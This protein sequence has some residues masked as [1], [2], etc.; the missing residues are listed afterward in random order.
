MKRVLRETKVK[1]RF[2]EHDLRAKASSDADSDEFAQKLL[3][4][5]NI[6]I[7]KRVY[8]RKAEKIV[9]LR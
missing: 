6:E 9:P 3:T 1:E 2:T 8:R 4:H 7:T 5:S